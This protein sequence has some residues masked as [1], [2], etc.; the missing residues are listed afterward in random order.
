MPGQREGAVRQGSV[1]KKAGAVEGVQDAAEDVQGAV[2]GDA[3]KPGP[4]TRL[5]QGMLGFWPLGLVLFALLL[6]VFYRPNPGLLVCFLDVGQGDG[7][8][9]RAEHGG[10]FFLDG[11]STS[12]SQVGEYRIL[13]FLKCRGVR[14]VEGWFVS[15]ADEDHISG[16]KEV[17]ESGYPV[18]RLFLSQFIPRDEAWEELCRLARAY[19]TEIVYLGP[20]DVVGSGELSFTCLYPRQ[21]GAERNDASMALYMDSPHLTAF[22][23]GD[24]STKTER[25]LAQGY[26]RGPVDL[27]KAIHHGSDGSNSAALLELLRPRVSVVSCAAEN[28]YGHPGKYAVERMEAQGSLMLYTMEGG[29]IT[30]G[31]DKKGIWVEEF[32]EKEE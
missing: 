18:E 3:R 25:E 6:L 16:L 32:V 2:A 11:G 13:S 31:A 26:D 24:L 20:G 9:I 14:R 10:S 27:Y 23:G 8:Y 22:F 7:I 17:W 5:M 1:S 12:E 28:S 21:E 19:E 4:V 29:Q 30:V 15:H